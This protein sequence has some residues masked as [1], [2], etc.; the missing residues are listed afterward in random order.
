M[1][2]GQQL[3]EEERELPGG[4]SPSSLP[5]PPPF[6]EVVCKSSGKVRRFA[7]GTEAGYALYLINRKLDFGLP[8]ALCIEAAK[9]GEEPVNF[10][11]NA[12]LVNYGDGWRLQTTIEEDYGEARRMKME[13]KQPRYGVDGAKPNLTERRASKPSSSVSLAY[14]GKILLAFVFMFL[15]GGLLTLFL[16][17][18]PSLISVV[19][20]SA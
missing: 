17:T 12:V 16:E 19:F 4:S 7:A 13:S 3:E 1:A 5:R 9:E 14:V 18:L 10:G 2:D 20:P 6:L 11:P 8:Q 15:L